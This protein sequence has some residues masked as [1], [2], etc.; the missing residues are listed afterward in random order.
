V[1][2]VEDLKAKLVIRSKEIAQLT[3]KLEAANEEVEVSEVENLKAKL[4]TGSKDIAQL[5]SMLKAAN[6]EVQSL[7][8]QLNAITNSTSWR[9][10]GPARGMVTIARGRRQ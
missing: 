10:L 8:T 5:T 9:L 3:S 4:A 1:R 6:D 2:E 7:R